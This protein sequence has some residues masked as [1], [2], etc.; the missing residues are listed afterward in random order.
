MLPDN[1]AAVLS[2]DLEQHWCLP[3]RERWRGLMEKKNKEEELTNQGIRIKD[4]FCFQ[5]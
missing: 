3:A 2:E 5:T 1:A 4:F